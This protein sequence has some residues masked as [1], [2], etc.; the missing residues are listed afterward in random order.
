MS[1]VLRGMDGLIPINFQLIYIKFFAFAEESS[2]RNSWML[3]RKAAGTLSTTIATP[4]LNHHIQRSTARN[5]VQTCYKHGTNMV[6]TWYKHGTNGTNGTNIV[7]TW[8]NH[9]TIMVQTWYNHGTIMVQMVQ[10]VQ[11]WYKHCTNIVQT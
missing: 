6:Q 7:Q 1:G 5:M 3:D 10:M 4:N 11:T 9:G 8:Y 2:S